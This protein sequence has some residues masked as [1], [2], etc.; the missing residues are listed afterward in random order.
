MGQIS[1]T[2]WVP[3]RPGQG[4]MIAHAC[5]ADKE[6]A[7]P[8]KLS[9]ML[10]LKAPRFPRG[11]LL[12]GNS[13]EPPP[14]FVPG[15]LL[16]NF[17]V[18]P[19]TKVTTAGDVELFVVIIGHAVPA[20]DNVTEHPADF[21]L[22]QLRQGESVFLSALDDF[23][24]RYTVVFG[25]AD[26]MHVANDATGMRS[27]F[28]AAQ[29]GVVAS[30]ALLVEC[31]LNGKIV[32][33]DLPFGYGYPG[34][35]TPYARTKILTPNTYYCMS[36][37]RIRRFWPIFTPPP[38]TVDEAAAEL[39]AASVVSMQAMSHGK[40][41]RLTLTAGLDSRVCL[42]IALHAGVLVQAYTYG[43]QAV[44]KLDQDLAVQ[45]AQQFGLEHSI[46]GEKKREPLLRERIEEAHY[47]THHAPWIGA[48]REHF[49]DISDL[50]VLGNALEI[51]RANYMPSRR[52]GTP[53]P[54]SADT[55]AGLHYNWF[56]DT[57]K[58]QVS[59][60]GRDRYHEAS[61]AA[62]ETFIRDTE[63]DTVSGMLDPFD[64]FYWEHRMAVWQGVAMGERDFYGDPFVPFNSRRVFEHMLG[65]PA[66]SRHAN[67]T[68]IRTLALVDSALLEV[69]VN[70]KQLVPPQ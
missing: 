52:K 2:Y 45:L 9:S 31:A 8:G 37:N 36:A 7:S 27:V 10:H 60:Y 55:M 56:S 70:Q 68:A 47:A 29:G 39:L 43:D 20:T 61:A 63:Y 46:L 65:V 16:P 17:Y 49:T 26:H 18:H 15:P 6:R 69:P 40:T 58:Q 54:V 24:G 51:G 48:L 64:Q 35:Q 30:H 21:L 5:H 1:S 33:S 53:P 62:F 66:P 25:S 42:A 3:A 23:G 34:N 32:K 44:T 12:A 11:F 14:T 41:V 67:A 57:T 38:R 19:W 22:Q 28:Y 4:Q 13:V 59:A 50:A